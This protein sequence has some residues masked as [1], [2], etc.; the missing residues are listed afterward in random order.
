MPSAQGKLQSLI[1]RIREAVGVLRVLL[2]EEK[3]PQAHGGPRRVGP[4]EANLQ[5]PEGR[6]G[7]YVRDGGIVDLQTDGA[8]LGI[9]PSGW[10]VEAPSGYLGVADLVVRG[11]RVSLQI[12][13][14]GYYLSGRQLHPEMVVGTKMATA[15]WDLEVLALP[16][17]LKPMDSERIGASPKPPAS[18]PV[19]VGNTPLLAVRLGDLFRWLEST[20]EPESLSWVDQVILE[21]QRGLGGA[22]RE[23]STGQQ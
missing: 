13:P 23:G 2:G 12:P 7:L 15:L 20:R 22:S 4:G 18:R 9:R 1:Q 14:D 11:E 6:H 19:V 8:V 21:L 5:H 3:R 10:T 17:S 16:G